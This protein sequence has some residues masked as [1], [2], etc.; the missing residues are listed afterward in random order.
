MGETHVVEA[1][2]SALGDGSGT[3]RKAAAEALGKM[4][5]PTWRQWVRGDA[6]DFERLGQ[7]RDPRAVGP[8]IRALG[9]KYDGG[10]RELAAVALG[11]L[12]NVGAVQPLIEALGDGAWL[13]RKAAA[14]ALADFARSS[15]GSLRGQWRMIAKKVAEPRRS[16]DSCSHG[17]GGIGLA[18]PAPP[19][20]EPF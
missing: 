16:F 4:G 3:V 15:P 12:G 13:V 6:A 20:G 10:V 7:S 2:T 19:P 1:L 11:K 5:D 14:E 9:H 17:D 18:F 8:L